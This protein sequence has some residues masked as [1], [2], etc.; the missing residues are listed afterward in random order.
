MKTTKLLGRF[1]KFRDVPLGDCLFIRAGGSTHLG[2]KFDV[3]Q[4]RPFSAVTLFNHPT[5]SGAPGMVQV[6][7]DAS[8]FHLPE[9]EFDFKSSSENISF[10]RNEEIPGTILQDA[11]NLFL[12]SYLDN[13]TLV[14]I[15]LLTGSAQYHLVDYDFVVIKNWSVIHSSFR[16]QDSIVLFHRD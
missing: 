1:I 6:S 7:A 3:P 4:F 5:L 15:D 10:Q 14:Y 9:A 11:K 16:V 12:V 13:S 2:M 8:V